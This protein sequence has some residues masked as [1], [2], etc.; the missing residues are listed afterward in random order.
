[1]TSNKRYSSRDFII[2]NLNYTDLKIIFSSDI[3]IY[4]NW[5]FNFKQNLNFDFSEYDRIRNEII[6]LSK[7]DSFFKFERF[8]NF[9]NLKKLSNIFINLNNDPNWIDVFLAN[10]CLILEIDFSGKISFENLVKMCIQS[11]DEK[12]KNG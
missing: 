10:S 11:I 8:E 12:F 9:N 4:D 1:M 6:N 7:F 3:L 2:E 5:S